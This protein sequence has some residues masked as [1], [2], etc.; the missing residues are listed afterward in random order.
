MAVQR[1][2]PRRDAVPACSSVGVRRPREAG[3]E[4]ASQCG[5][6]RSAGG[7]PDRRVPDP[8]DDRATAG[9]LQYRCA[10]GRLHL[11]A[12]ATGSRRALG[13]GRATRSASSRESG[14]ACPRAEA[15]SRRPCTSPSALRPGL[16]FMTLHFP[17][18]VETNRLTIEA[19]DP[20]SGTAEFK[21]TAIRVDKLQA[22]TCPD[23]PPSDDGAA[24][25]RGTSC[26][27]R[28]ARDPR[29]RPTT[30]WSRGGHETEGDRTLLL[31]A[32]HALHASEGWISEGGLNYIC[33]RLTVPP[34]EA[35]GV[36]TFYAMFS[37]R[38][39]AEDRGA[40]LRRPRLPDPGREGA[41]R[42]ARGA[43]RRRR[44]DLGDEPLPRDVRAGAGDP[45]AALGPPGRGARR[46][47]P[48]DRPGGRR[49]RLDGHVCGGRHRAAGVGPRRS[50][51]PPA[52]P[53]GRRG[54]SVVDRRLSGGGRLRG[55]AARDRA[56]PRG[57]DP[58]DHR[59]EAPRPRRGGVPHRRQVEGGRRAVGAPALRDL[60]RRRI[61]TGHLQGPPRDGARSVRRD[62]G[63]HDRRLRHG[64]GTG[65]PLRP[66]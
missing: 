3:T 23:G 21:A 36:A 66:R 22:R 33:E 40:R 58:G 55:A 62:R 48:G 6:R 38:T 51:G 52:A 54:R 46:G 8:T 19:A 65:L 32:L 1:R 61:R 34:A 26:G 43:G 20:K 60:Q 25:R 50:L 35:Y 15:R 2:V 16:A 39:A 11:A 31:P 53:T 28:A 18:E 59:R 7:P 45:R 44:L 27:R 49:A 64:R 17:D 41:P 30:G 37:V 63:A 12:P 5:G 47:D 13:G 4:G 9:L 57:D 29:S 10:D 24:D 56:R 42:R 14:S